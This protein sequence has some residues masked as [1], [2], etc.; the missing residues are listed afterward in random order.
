MCE[1]CDPK[2]K[3]AEH[4]ESKLE[5]KRRVSLDTRD[6]GATGN[7]VVQRKEEN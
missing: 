2:S 1:Y 7:I 4:E 3:I 5:R 6:L